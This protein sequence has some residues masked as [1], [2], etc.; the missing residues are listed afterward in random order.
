MAEIDVVVIG[1]GQAALSSACSPSRAGVVSVVLGR[2]TAHPSAP[3]RA[4][5]GSG[6]RS[7]PG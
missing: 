2:R 3:R 1:A 6:R 7:A 4:R 5:R